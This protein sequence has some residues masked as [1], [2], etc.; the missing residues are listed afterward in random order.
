MKIHAAGRHEADGFS[1][2]AR[3]AVPG[4]NS[5]HTQYPSNYFTQSSTF[6]IFFRSWM[7]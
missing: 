3:H 6:P 7:N 4:I 2:G 1:V 5:W